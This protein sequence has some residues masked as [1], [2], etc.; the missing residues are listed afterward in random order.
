[1]NYLNIARAMSL[2]LLPS[3]DPARIVF[4]G[5]ASLSGARLL[6]LSLETRRRLES[7]VG[8]IHHFSLAS[9]PAFQDIFI[10]SLEFKPW[11]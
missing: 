10:D 11:S 6:L 2:G 1:G 5:N 4:L 3:L 9:Q 7:L 8:G